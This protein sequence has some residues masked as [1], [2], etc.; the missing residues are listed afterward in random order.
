[1]HKSILLV[2]GPD[3]VGKSTLINKLSEY[4]ILDSKKHL[5]LH[6]DGPKPHHSTPI[7][8]YILPINKALDMGSEWVLCDRGGAEVCFYEKYRRNIDID[9]AWTQ[10]FEE[11][12]ETNF[13][14]HK[15]I[16]IKRD[17]EWCRPRHIEEINRLWPNCTDYWRNSQLNMRKAEHE[18]Y[19]EYMDRYF[20][21]VSKFM[22]TILETNELSSEQIKELLT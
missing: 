7:H 17:W 20:S 12:V 10:R 11:Y 9:H 1:M 16:L 14:W 8:Q 22:P 6:F 3:R 18:C 4:L 5:V 19:Y 2:L 21:Y 13:A 15:T